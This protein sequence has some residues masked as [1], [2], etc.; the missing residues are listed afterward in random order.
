V[1]EE[2]QQ[3]TRSGEKPVGIRDGQKETIT[4]PALFL[5]SPKALGQAECNPQQK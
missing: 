3:V 2:N 1:A 5:A 4:H